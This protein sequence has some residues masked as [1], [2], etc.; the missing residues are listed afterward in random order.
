VDD[1]EDIRLFIR[2]ELGE[3]YHIE[4]AENGEVAQN[5]A[6]KNSPD[7]IITDV[8]MPVMDGFELCKR[9]KNCID[10]SHIPVIMLTAKSAR[11]NEIQGLSEGA[12]DYISKP[13][14]INVLRLKIENILRTRKRYRALFRT[15]ID[16]DPR[17]I[18]TTNYDKEYLGKAIELIED[19]LREKDIN[20]QFLCDEL[21]TSQSQLYRKLKAISGTSPNEFIRMVKLK[22]G[23]KMLADPALSISEIGYMLGFKA[24]AHFT[25]AFKACFGET[26]KEYRMKLL[27]DSEEEK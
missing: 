25:R 16:I 27:P 21:G 20:V 15:E 24:P 5:L 19:N 10:T 14:N 18:T 26:P 2:S 4:E 3:K 13:F 1:N 12:D 7:L 6:E 9:L 22:K 11:D 17:D 8:M 23:A